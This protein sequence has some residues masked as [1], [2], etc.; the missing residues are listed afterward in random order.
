MSRIC[1]R[2][3]GCMAQRAL[4][5]LTALLHP[6]RSGPTCNFTTSGCCRSLLTFGGSALQPV[7]TSGVLLS[8]QDCLGCGTRDPTN[9]SR[10]LTQLTRSIRVQDCEKLSTEDCQ[11][12]KTLKSRHQVSSSQTQCSHCDPHDQPRDRCHA[13]RGGRPRSLRSAASSGPIGVLPTRPCDP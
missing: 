13:G 8:V 5:D 7:R 1:V 2:M 11:V 4:R 9:Q 10:M 3:A 6:L 12:H